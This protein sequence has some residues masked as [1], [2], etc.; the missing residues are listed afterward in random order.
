MTSYYLF[1]IY[2]LYSK[3]PIFLLHGFYLFFQLCIL[4]RFLQ[5]YLIYCVLDNTTNRSIK[6]CHWSRSE[7]AVVSAHHG[8]VQ[9]PQVVSR[10]VLVKPL[11]EFLRNH[12]SNVLQMDVKVLWVGITLGREVSIQYENLPLGW[13]FE[14]RLVNRIGRSYEWQQIL[15]PPIIR[16]S[17]T[18]EVPVI[19]SMQK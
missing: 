15:L 18:L 10:K 2:H 16:N 1:L 6:S 14:G 5:H 4:G 11:H 3:H 8:V 17:S 13:D 7:F 19:L 12:H 9:H